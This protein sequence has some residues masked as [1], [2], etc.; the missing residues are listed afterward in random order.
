VVRLAL[1]IPSVA[2][3]KAFFLIAA[4]CDNGCPGHDRVEECGIGVAA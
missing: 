2:T 4:V 3:S 1:S